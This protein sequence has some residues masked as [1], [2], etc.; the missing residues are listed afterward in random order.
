MK[1]REWQGALASVSAVTVMPFTEDDRLDLD[2]HERAVG[3]LAAAVVGT[4]TVHGNAGEYC[5]LTSTERRAAVRLTVS[6][7]RQVP[8][9][10]GVGGDLPSATDDARDAAADGA[11]LVM[12]HQP[13][14][15]FRSV[16]GWVEYHRAIAAAVPELGVALYLRDPTITAPALRAL[17][18]EAPSWPRST[19][20]PTR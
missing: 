20:S 2:A 14:H 4:I 1:P 13:A 12:I 5:S 11:Q 19:R 8:V 7:A 6:A 9:I 17:A 3:R 18:E 15:P 16:E 10:V